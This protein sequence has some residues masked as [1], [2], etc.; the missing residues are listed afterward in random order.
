M[1][2]RERMEG[3]SVAGLGTAIALLLAALVIL[4]GFI[5]SRSGNIQGNPN[6]AFYSDDD[7]QT[8]FKDSAFHFPPFDHNGKTANG[9]LVYDDGNHKFV[10][11][12]YRFTPQ[13]AKALQ[14][15]YD[16]PPTGETGADAAAMLGQT[17]AIH[18]G[19]MEIKK[20]GGDWMPNW[21]MGNPR[22]TC[23][24]GTPALQVSP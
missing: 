4:Y 23:P 1:S 22:V 5:S 20:P 12:L 7:G 11:Y 16:N 18:S 15:A 21:K 13:A 8:Y 2:V 14:A 10:A 6:Q 19:G 9:A 24:D 17:P 3:T